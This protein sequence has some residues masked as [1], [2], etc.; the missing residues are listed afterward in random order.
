[1]CYYAGINLG[2]SAIH[3]FTGQSI[4]IFAADYVITEYS[5]KAVMGVPGHDVRDEVFAV[6]HHLPIT[7]VH[8]TLDSG[9]KILSNSDKVRKK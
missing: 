6:E 3:P 5:T 1:M 7:T 2:I 4:P 9:E 8:E